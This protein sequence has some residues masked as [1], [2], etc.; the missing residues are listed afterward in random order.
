GVCSDAAV[1]RV[2]TGLLWR[3]WSCDSGGGGAWQQGVADK[4]AAVRVVVVARDSDGES[5]VCSDAAV[6]RVVTG[7]LWSRW[8]CDSGGGGAWQQ[9][10]ADKEAA[11]RVAAVVVVARDSDGERRVR[12][13]DMMGRIDRVI[14]SIFGFAEKS[15]PEKFS[16]GGVVAV[17]GG[18]LA[19]R[20]WGVGKSIIISVC[21]Y[22]IRWNE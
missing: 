22:L 21:V 16:G 6:V 19:G 9:G 14:R 1:V 7:L 17:A 3:R 18:W 10:V 2:V 20:W 12:E 11:V 4:E 15:P 5:G 8:G 13:S